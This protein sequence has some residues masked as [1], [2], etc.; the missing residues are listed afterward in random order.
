MQLTPKINKISDDF[1]SYIDAKRD[2][3][4]GNIADLMQVLNMWACE[5][6]DVVSCHEYLC[7]AVSWLGRSCFE[8]VKYLNILICIKLPSA[9]QLANITATHLECIDC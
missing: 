6:T 9:I 8:C 1:N 3:Q 2:S 7:M 4:T 5:G